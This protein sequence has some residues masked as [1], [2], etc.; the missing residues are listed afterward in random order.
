MWSRSLFQ[1]SQ[2]SLSGEPDILLLRIRGRAPHRNHVASADFSAALLS[3]DLR[4]SVAGDDHRVAVRSHLNAEAAILMGG[5]DGDVG[6]VNLR[7][8]LAVLKK[9]RR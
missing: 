6:R 1:R 7:L 9:R 2:S 3:G 5:M 4:L 8:C